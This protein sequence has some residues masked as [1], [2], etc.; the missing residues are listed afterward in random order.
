M[1]I[2][3]ELLEEHKAC[4]EQVSLFRRTFPE[5]GES[6]VQALLKASEAGLDITWLERFI[7]DESWAAYD[8]ACAEPLAAY[9]KAM[10]ESRAAYDK[11]RKEPR[12]AYDKALKESWAAYNKARKEPQAAY[13]KAMK[14]PWAAYNKACAVALSKALG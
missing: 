14:E 10:K 9:N 1:K 5:G 12:A 11:A 7:P 3:A 4:E 13:D 2:T 6:T 8:K